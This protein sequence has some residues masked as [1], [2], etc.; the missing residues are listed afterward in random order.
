MMSR[1]KSVTYFIF[2]LIAMLANGNVIASDS[3]LSE[4]HSVV[5]DNSYSNDVV[6]EDP[7]F[8]VLLAH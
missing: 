8:W 6:D 7:S 3:T 4:N 5:A 1:T 2:L